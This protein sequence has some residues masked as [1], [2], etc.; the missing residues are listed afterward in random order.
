MAQTY[1]KRKQHMLRVRPDN[2]GKKYKRHKQR[3]PNITLNK[4]LKAIKGSGGLKTKIAKR[5][6]LDRATIDLALQK[7]KFLKALQLYEEELD[8]VI[9]LAEKTVQHCMKQR[10]HLPT[11]AATARWFL[12]KKDKAQERGYSSKQTISLQGG[13]TPIQVEMKGL[14]TITPAQLAAMPIAVRK[15]LLEAIENESGEGD[16]N[17]QGTGKPRFP[18]ITISKHNGVQ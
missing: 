10:D 6:G 4:F 2:T 16:E 5:M 3:G 11:A 1:E 15:S 18:R 17:G 9:D 12:E 13:A 7:P 8:S 14:V